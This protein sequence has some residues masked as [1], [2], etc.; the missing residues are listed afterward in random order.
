MGR[1]ILGD[2]RGPKY[3]RQLFKKLQNFVY[4]RSGDEWK[5]F[6]LAKLSALRTFVR[7]NGE[8]AAGVGFFLGILLVL[9]FKI[10]VTVAIVAVVAVVSVIVWADARPED[11]KNP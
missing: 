8:K 6:F 1:N 2:G 5:A 9:F 3:M 11:W 4:S 7:E 10:A